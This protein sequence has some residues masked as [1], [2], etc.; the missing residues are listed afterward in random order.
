MR[1]DKGSGL[2]WF[3]CLL[4]LISLFAGT[5]I[6]ASSEFLIARQVTDIAEQFALAVKTRLRSSANVAEVGKGIFMEIYP[7][8]RLQ[9]LSVRSISLEPGRT[10]KAV[11]CASWSSPISFVSAQRQICEVAYSR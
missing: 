8:Y 3:I 9:Q 10:V 2:I 11:V 6:S 5:L 7:Q 4:A 1:A